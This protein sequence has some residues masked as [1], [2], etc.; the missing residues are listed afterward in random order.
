MSA[1]PR[2]PLAGLRAGFARLREQLE[3]E[4]APTQW[5]EGNRVEL[6]VGGD[7]YFPRLLAAI[8]AAR[9][10]I[11]LETYIFADDA[12]GE[13]V[14]VALAE[15]AARGVEVRLTIDGYGG[16]E[17]AHAL[18]RELPVHGAGVRIFRPAR[19]W[20]L[21][22]ELLRRMHRKV[23]VVDERIAFVGGINVIGDY[24]DVPELPGGGRAPRFD[25]AVACEGPIVGAIALAAAR[26]WWGLA[27]FGR[28]SAG[29]RRPRP[30]D[31]APQARFA[32]G[33]RAAL[34]VRD[35]VRHRRSI[36][37]AYLDALESARREVLIANAYFLPGRRFRDTLIDCA[38]RGVAVK[39][40]LQGHAEYALQFRGQRALYGRLLDAGVEIHEYTAS[41][42]HAKVAVVDGRWATV[43]SSNIDPYSL[44]LAREANVVL[45]CPRFAAVLRGELVRALRDASRPLRAA[46]YAA[47]SLW[48]HALDRLAYQVLRLAAVVLAR[49]RDY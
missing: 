26:Q 40:L 12:T 14:A 1:P 17:H 47:R 15:A 45:E 13:R 38:R 42:L 30:E 36:E 39:L 23:A 48:T 43:G 33:A 37:R 7:A 49:G 6:L 10:S 32:D 31:I 20:R 3:G 34:L 41:Y 16:G 21:E 11:Y 19:V 27:L 5:S 46:D 24:T 2:E 9:R 25:F 29:G 4:Y 8:E 18:A 35:N 28:G 22:R 44:L